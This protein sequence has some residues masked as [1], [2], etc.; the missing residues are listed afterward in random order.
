MNRVWSDNDTY[1]RT[2]KMYGVN[3][4]NELDKLDIITFI[5]DVIEKFITPSEKQPIKYGKY[6]IDNAILSRL[7]NNDRLNSEI[8][9][10]LTKVRDKMWYSNDRTISLDDFER[11]LNGYP[12]SM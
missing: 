12:Y 9:D 1:I 2:Y 7:Q 10:W 6:D 11:V 4:I 8:Y 3:T 5:L